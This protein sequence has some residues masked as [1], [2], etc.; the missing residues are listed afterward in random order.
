MRKIVGIVDDDAAMLRSVDRFLRAAG[1]DTELYSSGEE[2]LRSLEASKA[3][4]L[5]IDIHLGGISGI[6]LRQ[7]L[8]A[9]GFAVPTIFIS[10]LA[11]QLTEEAASDAGCVAFLHKPFSAHLLMKAV[12]QGIQP[13]A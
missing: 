2:L 1:Y 8:E 10:G 12:E 5:I 9:L 13:A 7:R 11:N 4:C 6:E 3:S